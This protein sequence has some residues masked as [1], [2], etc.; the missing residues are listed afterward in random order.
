MKCPACNKSSL[1]LLGT[2]PFRDFDG[3]AFNCSGKFLFC[4]N[5]GMVR[6]ITGLTD[7]EIAAHYTKDSL[8]VSQSG[9]GI[10]GSSKEDI[11]RYA[12][13]LSFIKENNISVGYI[14]DIGCSRGGFLRYLSSIEPTA[15]VIGVDCDYRSLES[16]RCAGFEAITGD[17][18]DLP[19]SSNSFD[20]LTYLHVLEHIYDVER[21]LAEA[22]RVLKV[23]GGLVIEVPDSTRYFDSE[24]YV[25]PMFW[26]AMKEHVNHFCLTSLAITL[27]RNGFQ[28]QAYSQSNQPM[29][30][31]QHYP[32]LLVY[33]K[34]KNFV[35]ESKIRRKQK[36]S[37][38]PLSFALDTQRMQVIAEN[39]RLKVGSSSIAFWGIGL[40]FFALYGYLAPLLSNSFSLIDSNSAKT[41]L[42]VDGNP[43]K[44]FSKIDIDRTVLVCSYMVASEIKDQACSHGCSPE[45]VKTMLDFS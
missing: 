38:F 7:Q 19:L 8:Y 27:A 40:E 5:C 21:L 10:G 44:S 15:T 6:V 34:K 29:K 25:G 31:N 17:V 23:N 33:A 32:S 20:T 14:A 43:V 26:L 9:V 11:L 39:I 30:G 22:S 28:L 41:G 37:D 35:A 3:A 2:V 13:Y 16:L 36:I 45:S 12:Y 4:D 18:F 1:N 42:A 24:T